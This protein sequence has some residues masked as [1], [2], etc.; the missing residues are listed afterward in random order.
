MSAVR[1]TINMLRRL[2]ENRK[3]GKPGSYVDNARW[4]LDQAINRRAGWPDDPGCSRGSCRPVNGRY[5]K[6]AEG[7]SLNHL[8]LLARELNTPRLIVRPERCG[9][10]R[11]LIEARLPNR[12]YTDSD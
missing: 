10:W 9:E 11:R 3:E 5:P 7:E 4:L 12:L 8:Y 1:N 6:K 2:I